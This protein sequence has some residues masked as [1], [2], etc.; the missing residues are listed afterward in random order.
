MVKCKQSLKDG[1]PCKNDGL[2]AFEGYCLTHWDMHRR[3]AI[4]VR[5]ETAKDRQLKAARARIEALSRREA[6]K[7]KPLVLVFEDAP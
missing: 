4:G 1:R 2:R 6:R 5:V 3:H 7:K